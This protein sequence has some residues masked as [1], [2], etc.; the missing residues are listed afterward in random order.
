MTRQLWIYLGLAILV[1]LSWLV[2]DR[3]AP[4][5][6]RVQ[7]A[8]GH[9]PDSFSKKFTKITMTEEGKPKNI[10]FAEFMVHF[11]DDDT[12]E[13]ERPVF[14][15]FNKESP[16]WVV[17]AET[18][19]ITAEGKTIRLGNNVRITRDPAPGIEPVTINTA[20]L[21]IQ[22]EIDFAQTDEYAELISNRNHISGIGLSLTFGDYKQINLH[23]NVKGIYDAR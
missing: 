22:P 1:L 19:F 6:I 2:A 20:N 12:T 7:P 21:V 5:S 3:M 10:L 18:G 23:S 13:L 16:P 15:Y 14:T 11:Q 9:Q 17:H 4:R 8:A